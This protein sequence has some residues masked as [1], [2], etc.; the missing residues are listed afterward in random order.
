[1]FL[2]SI[3]MTTA[4]K[5]ISLCNLRV[6]Q[7]NALQWNN[8]W[9]KKETSAYVNI[10]NPTYRSKRSSTAAKK[11]NLKAALM[12]ACSFYTQMLTWEKTYN[13][14]KSQISVKQNS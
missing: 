7:Q 4:G 11:S 9:Q 5:N 13:L 6:K 12:K 8:C 1:M 10:T 2:F 14:T 3:L